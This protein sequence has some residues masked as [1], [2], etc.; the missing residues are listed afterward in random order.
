VGTVTELMHRNLFDVFGERDP[1]RRAQAIAETYAEDVVWHDPEGTVT[2]RPA[3]AARAA[4]LLD[5]APGFEFAARGQARESA[6]SLG[7]LSW[8]FGP[9]GGA[10]VVTG[11]DVALV[12]G[13]VVQTLHT[14]LDG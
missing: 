12:S 10:P 8:R 1:E 14:F 4:A 13:G 9:P 7:V 2:G 11:M 3:L 5:G 6:G